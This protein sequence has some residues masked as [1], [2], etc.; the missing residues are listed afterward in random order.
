M[1]LGVNPNGRD[2]LA[3]ARPRGVSHVRSKVIANF[4]SREYKK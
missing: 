2:G 3:Q 4:G 1:L